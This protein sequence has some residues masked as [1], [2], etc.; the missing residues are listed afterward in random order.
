MPAQRKNAT[1]TKY[2]RALNEYLEGFLRR[3]QPLLE[4]EGEVVGPTVEARFDGLWKEGNVPGW[5][6]EA[7]GLAQQ[8]QQG[9]EGV[10]GAPRCVWMFWMEVWLGVSCRYTRLSSRPRV[11]RPDPLPPQLI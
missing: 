1:Y 5:P 9:A 7:T 11:V 4:L 8:L 6:L 2:V 10:A 3:T